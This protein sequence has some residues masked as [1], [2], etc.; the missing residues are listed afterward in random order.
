ME[1]LKCVHIFVEGRVQGVGFRYFVKKAA[2]ENHLTGWVRNLYD[3]RV[4]ILA[5]GEESQ[6]NKFIAIV[7]IGPG[8]ALV[9]KLET[10]WLNPDNRINRF[11]I[12]ASL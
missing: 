6:L 11:S 2:E 4:E 9:S 10:N 7:Q 12:A 1:E 5:Q 3:D 8:S